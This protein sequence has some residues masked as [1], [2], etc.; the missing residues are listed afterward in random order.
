MLC[1][2]SIPLSLCSIFSRCVSLF[3]FGDLFI[4]SQEFLMTSGTSCRI[5]FIWSEYSNKLTDPRCSAGS[6]TSYYWLLNLI[7]SNLK[8]QLEILQYNNILWPKEKKLLCCYLTRQNIMLQGCRLQTLY[9]LHTFS[10][11]TWQ[12]AKKAIFLRHCI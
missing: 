4:K 7:R 2:Q 1:T 12:N 9:L 3:V 8:Q 6:T 11:N 5:F 10:I